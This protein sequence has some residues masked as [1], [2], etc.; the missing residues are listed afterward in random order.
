MNRMEGAGECVSSA[1]GATSRPG[2]SVE[3]K[4]AKSRAYVLVET[5]MGKSL[6]VSQAL[7]GYDWADTVERMVGAFD[8]MV[9]ARDIA[10]GRTPER[11]KSIVEQIDGVLRV[12]VCPLSPAVDTSWRP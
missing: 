7:R 1:S 4:D 5:V 9:G 6:E 3:R 12:V 10:E 11:V 8:I 2:L